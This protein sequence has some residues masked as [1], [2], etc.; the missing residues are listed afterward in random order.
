M[1]SYVNFLDTYL[2]DILFVIAMVF[3]AGFVMAL[4]WIPYYFAS[5]RHAKRRLAIKRSGMA[6]WGYI[7]TTFSRQK[8]SRPT[9]TT[10]GYWYTVHYA[11]YT[12]TDHLGRS[13]IGVFPQKK[14]CMYAA[15]DQVTVYYDP[16]SPDDHCTD[17]QIEED[18][19]IKA[20]IYGLCIFLAVVTL[21]G[22][23]VY[24]LQR[25]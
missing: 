6:A 22:I 11:Q 12:F 15:G 23:V 19:Y 3:C 24:F 4:V 16:N 17:R 5:A 20:S 18:S 10:P 13:H 8:H 25:K 9:D 7:V 21:A 1:D 14:K 2:N